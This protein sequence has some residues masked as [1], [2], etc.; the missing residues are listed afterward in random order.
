[1]GGRLALGVGGTLVTAAVVR[2]DR[3]G[4]HELRVFRMVNNL[5]DG[6]YRPAW[7]VMQLGALGTVPV[8]AGV[9]WAGGDRSLARRM[10]ISG[11]TTWALSKAAKRLVRRPRPA[12]LVPGVR[13]RGREATGLGYLSGHAGVAVA[14]ALAA[15]PRVGPRWR[16]VLLAASTA[17]GLTRI[18]VGA[19][20]PLDVAGGTSLGLAVDAL[21]ALAQIGPDQSSSEDPAT[22]SPMGQSARSR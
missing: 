5:P 20:L 22:R 11:T 7:S 2:R 16:P 18:Y 19:H 3:V 10:L 4:R 13:C 15:G 17:V 12:G 21:A 1:M 6:L 9:A 14:L 8:A